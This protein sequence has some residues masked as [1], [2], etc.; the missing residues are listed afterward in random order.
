VWEEGNIGTVLRRA[1]MERGS[2]WKKMLII[3]LETI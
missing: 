3:V 1:E 2:G